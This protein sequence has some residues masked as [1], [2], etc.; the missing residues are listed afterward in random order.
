MFLV[1]LW[2]YC[3]LESSATRQCFFLAPAEGC[4]LL[5][6]SQGPFR[7]KGDFGRTDARTQVQTN[8]R[9]DN[10][11]KG[12]RYECHHMSQAVTDLPCSPLSPHCNSSC[13]C[14]QE[15]EGSRRSRRSRSRRSRSRSRELAGGLLCLLCRSH[16]HCCSVVLCV[17]S[18]RELSIKV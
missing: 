3:N 16:D 8:R 4:S 13:Y 1:S 18:E 5:A 10:R 14:L 9:T 2:N 7:P 17:K 11:F 15:Q 6:A 12:V